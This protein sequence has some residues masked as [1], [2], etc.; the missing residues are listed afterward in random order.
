MRKLIIN[1]TMDL[2]AKFNLIYSVYRLG[3][4]YLFVKEIECQLDALFTELNSEY[5]HELDL[6]TISVHFQ[7]FRNH[8][9][10]LSC[11]K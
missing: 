6:Y 8:G 5:Y 3:L 10:N 9:Y 2:N 4:A 11:G 7:V 1:P